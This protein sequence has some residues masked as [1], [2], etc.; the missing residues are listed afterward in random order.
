[1]LWSRRN[2]RASFI[3]V[4]EWLLGGLAC[5]YRANLGAVCKFALHLSSICPLEGP[6]CP[7]MEPAHPLWDDHCGPSEFQAQT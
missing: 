1:M 3:P 7:G 4:S 6:S 2:S 5:P